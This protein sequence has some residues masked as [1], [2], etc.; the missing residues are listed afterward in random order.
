[1]HK[2]FHLYGT[3]LAARLAKRPVEDAQKIAYAAQ[4]VDDFTYGEYASCQ[5]FSK[6]L[7]EELDI[8]KCYWTTFHFLPFD[9][10]LDDKEERFITSPDGGLA[11]VIE[12]ELPCDNMAD[13]DDRLAFEG[14]A[15][16]VIADTYAHQ[17]FAGI[18]SGLN[19]VKNLKMCGQQ[20]LSLINSNNHVPVFFAE[21]FK[22][23]SIGHGTAGK[24][25]DISWIDFCYIDSSGNTVTR[26]NAEIFA[27][28]FVKLYELLKGDFSK[29]AEIRDKI[30]NRLISVR[31]DRNLNKEESYYEENDNTFRDM[32]NE[33][34]FELEDF[35]G[36]AEFNA[37][38]GYQDYI[39]EVNKLA[40]DFKNCSDA[41]QKEKR[42][43][44]LS[45]NH[46]FYASYKIR[47]LVTPSILDSEV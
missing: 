34:F 37:L 32:L 10:G 35:S 15:M 8:L 3:Y 29:S 36:E 26:D 11:Q 1:M 14:A 7:T 43:R 17:G 23:C 47:E 33:N 2:D 5:G 22:K 20:G 31:N 16:H 42:F 40:A 6:I 30:K 4:A 28:A 46:F 39:D 25:P 27:D 18:P 44:E 38:S 41:D 24:A 12:A 45:N 21:W 19:V 13:N 9:L